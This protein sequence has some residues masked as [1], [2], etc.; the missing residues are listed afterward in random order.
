M[1][2]QKLVLSQQKTYKNHIYRNLFPKQNCLA[3]TGLVD[4]EDSAE[5]LIMFI[6]DF[7]PYKKPDVKKDVRFFCSN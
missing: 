5:S 2:K 7:A 3:L 4:I 6:G 1:Y